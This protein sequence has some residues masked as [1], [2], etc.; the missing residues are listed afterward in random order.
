MTPDIL[1]DGLHFPECPRWRDGHLWFSDVH[2]QRVMAC[3][4]ELTG[5]RC[6][7]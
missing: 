7:S 4:A 1:I 6:S 3:W 2:G 5:A